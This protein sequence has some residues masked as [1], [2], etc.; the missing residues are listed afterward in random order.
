MKKKHLFH[1]SSDV[2]LYTRGPESPSHVSI[3]AR[4]AVSHSGCI[5]PPPS[6]MRAATLRCPLRLSQPLFGAAFSVALSAAA[7]CE[8]RALHVLRESRSARSA[9]TSCV[10]FASRPS[11]SWLQPRLLVGGGGAARFFVSRGCYARACCANTCSS[12][13]GRMEKN[14]T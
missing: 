9:R 7:P 11:P 5:N 4:M 12:S 3:C 6:A 8:R 2:R 1:S 14:T 10:P 13:V